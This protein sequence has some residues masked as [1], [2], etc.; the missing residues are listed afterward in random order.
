MKNSFH[1]FFLR[2][3]S[4]KICLL[5]FFVWASILFI[6]SQGWSGGWHFDDEP[7]LSSLSVVFDNGKFDWNAAQDFV[8][9]GDAGPLG[10]PIALISFLID[11]SA[12]PLNPSSFLYTNSLLHGINALLLC[13]L[14]LAVLCQR[15]QAN[16][17][18]AWIAVIASML[19]FLQPILVSGVLMVVQRMA[20]LS[21]SF[22]LLGAWMYVL[23]RQKLETRPVIGWVL[24]FLGLCGG[25]FL[26]VFTKE[27][28]ALLP[29]LLWMLDKNLLIQP[30][31][32]GFQK[33]LWK[34]F[35][36]FCFYIPAILIFIYLLNIVINADT[37]YMSRNFDLHE[38]LWSQS[39][40]LWDYL[41][42]AFFPRALAFGPF[43]DDYP[44]FGAS[45]VSIFSVVAWLVVFIVF[46]CFRHR[47]RW[48]LFAL[49]WFLIGH[50]VESTVVPLELYFEHRNYLPLAGP[51]L[52]IVAF[53]YQLAVNNK[54]RQRM[55]IVLLSIYSLLLATVLWQVTSLFGQSTT[56]A[57]LWYERHPQ[58]VRA[59][60]YLAAD[61]SERGDVKSALE[62]LD[63]TAMRHSGS[64]GALYLQ[65][66]Q[67]ACVLKA[68]KK[69]LQFRFEQVLS[70]LSQ[71]SRRFSIYDSLSKLEY[72]LKEDACNDFLTVNMLV[73]I[74]E[75]ALN[76]EQM[77]SVPMERSNMHYFL[78]GLYMDARD[79][80]NTMRHLEA[81]MQAVPQPQTMDLMVNM[82][83]SAGLKQEAL[84]LMDKYE[85]I[86]PKNPWLRN[87]Q[88]Q[89]WQQLRKKLDS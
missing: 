56:A 87:K 67:L 11:G 31:L 47:S 2:S 33:R 64:A 16:F 77:S 76:N 39:V 61:L 80:N 54:R 89:E 75:T 26:G 35:N 78:S 3:A 14:W 45:P 65:G 70:N 15:E 34:L 74:T 59:A 18:N 69:E 88:Q 27:Q 43:H 24:I 82:L 40:I 50:S 48:P 53:F 22:M 81:A 71:V 51:L 6:Y 52:A 17:H 85:P 25:T 49:L 42:L 66:L 58:S 21:S 46:W 38:R 32:K 37:A 68:P 41:R 63:R 73:Q 83:I 28:A 57:Q 4:I 36:I 44:V 13:G 55:M 86:W 19:W 10:R 1:A 84:E 12:W 72:I 79:L 23:G 9:S 60:Q 62:V 8:F 29:I 5:L 7:N 20:L 30:S